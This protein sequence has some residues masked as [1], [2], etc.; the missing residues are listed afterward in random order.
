MLLIPVIT[1]ASPG[2]PNTLVLNTWRR[3]CV[4]V[5]TASDFQTQDSPFQVCPSVWHQVPRASG[6]QNGFCSSK[7]SGI[8]WQL[9][10]LSVPQFS[11]LYNGDDR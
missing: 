3:W 11:H 4:P 5:Y 6:G 2:R 7:E 10:K 9:P 1:A 8:C